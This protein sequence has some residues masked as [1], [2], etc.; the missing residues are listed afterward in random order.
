[1]TFLI[2]SKLLIEQE[3]FSAELIDNNTK[4]RV[5]IDELNEEHLDLIP[6]AFDFPV[7][8][9]PE[10]TYQGHLTYVIDRESDM[11]ETATLTIEAN[12]PV[13]YTHLTLPTTRLVCR[14]RWSPYH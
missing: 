13:S 12:D 7:L 6:F 2:L 11:I 1:M 4:Y 8:L 14:S 9:S 5:E 3:D 10:T